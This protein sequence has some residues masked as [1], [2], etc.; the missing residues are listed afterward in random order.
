MLKIP[1]NLDRDEAPYG[2]KASISPKRVRNLANY[3]AMLTVSVNLLEHLITM[4]REIGSPSANSYRLSLG[5]FVA[6]IHHTY[7][8]SA[9]F[10]KPCLAGTSIEEALHNSEYSGWFRL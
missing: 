7:F 1:A 8:N 9:D 4:A 3:T 5:G 2:T 10:Y 6:N